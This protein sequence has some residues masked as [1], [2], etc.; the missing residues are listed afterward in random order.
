M[1]I[2]KFLVENGVDVNGIPNANS[3]AINYTTPLH[4]AT[5]LGNNEAPILY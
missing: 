5:K 4:L 3:D 2:V 1:N